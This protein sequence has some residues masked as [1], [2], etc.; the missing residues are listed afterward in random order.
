MLHCNRIERHCSQ[1]TFII[2][3]G[4]ETIANYSTFIR[5]SLLHLRCMKPSNK[6]TWVW[7]W[8]CSRYVVRLHLEIHTCLSVIIRPRG[9]YWW[10]VRGLRQSFLSLDFSSFHNLTVAT[11]YRVSAARIVTKCFL[12]WKG[13]SR[14]IMYCTFNRTIF[15]GRLLGKPIHYGIYVTQN[16]IWTTGWCLIFCFDLIVR[17]NVPWWKLKQLNALWEQ[18][19]N[20]NVAHFTWNQNPKC[21]YYQFE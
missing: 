2:S 7:S 15:I 14:L 3:L 20:R 16:T 10:P 5:L 8:V 1:Q 17:T 6:H 19:F 12:K 18:L 13:A 11:N 4:T 9:T 21:G